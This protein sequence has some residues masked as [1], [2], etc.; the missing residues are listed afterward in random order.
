S[1]HCEVRPL[2][3]AY[4]EDTIGELALATEHLNLV[5]DLDLLQVLEH[6]TGAQTADVAHQD[7]IAT[8]PRTSRVLGM[9]SVE[10]WH[11]PGPAAISFDE[12][13]RDDLAVETDARDHHACDRQA[14]RYRRRA[15]EGRNNRR[16]RSGPRCWGLGRR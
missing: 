3:R 16:P 14:L 7:R 10:R 11:K 6:I 4:F 15:N 9:P 1:D 5:A 12:R 13:S 8:L 2:D